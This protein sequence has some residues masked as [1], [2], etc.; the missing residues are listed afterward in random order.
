LSGGHSAENPV[1]SSGASQR[2]KLGLHSV[3]FGRNC[4]G[5]HVALVPVQYADNSQNPPAV[6]HTVMFVSNLSVGHDDEF[7]SQNSTLSHGPV[8]GLHSVPAG[9]TVFVE[10]LQQIPE[11]QGLGVA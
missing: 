11:A 4:F 7:P 10:V 1:Q 2:S 6:L 8:A 5:G 9:I 3:V